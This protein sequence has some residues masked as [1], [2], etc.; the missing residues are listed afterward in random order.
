MNP[1]D[2]GR[3]SS[4][5]TETSNS[6]ESECASEHREQPEG[7]RHQG[8]PKEVANAF[9]SLGLTSFGGPVAH[10]AYFRTEFVERRRWLSE[11][12][13][14]DLVALCQF[15]PGPASS[16][17]GFALGWMRG[18]YKGALAAFLAFTLPS[19]LLMLLLALG[20]ASF[21]SPTGSGL[22]SGLHLVAVAVIAHAIW[23]MSKNLT[24][25]RTRLAIAWFALT[26]ALVMGGTWGQI[27]ALG[28]GAM[29]GHFFCGKTASPT[30]AAT[31]TSDAQSPP[32]H[33][34][35]HG[36]NQSLV[37]VPANLSKKAAIAFVA[38]LVV[39]GILAGLGGTL[40]LFDSFYRSGALVFGGGHVV[41]PLLE[42]E[43]VATGNVSPND[44]LTGYAGAQA[45]PGPLFTF[46]AYLGAISSEGPGGLIGALIALIAIFL[47]GFLL[48]IAVLPRWHY[49]SSLR[50][51][52]KPLMG[53]NA[54]VV[55]LLGAALF[56]PVWTSAVNG[57]REFALMLA[58][59]LMLQVWKQPAWAVV[60]AGAIGGIV[61]L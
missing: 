32:T 46:A 13:Y 61:F 3:D 14:A 44:F 4:E 39:P 35:T 18:G 19:A 41:L 52:R 55:G 26:I 33:E 2:P 21:D 5:P 51:V 10:L 6:T 11:E 25:D 9:F 28:W 43:L 59:F 31:G 42:A 23:G 38:L 17:V 40:A 27:L 50:A 58:C 7:T 29:L 12:K 20:A 16:Q 30:S 34:E 15:L 36:D 53:V 48:L 60:L 8:T 24:P 37:K 54:A 49:W 1:N 45:V 57:G 56:Q 47:P 22:L